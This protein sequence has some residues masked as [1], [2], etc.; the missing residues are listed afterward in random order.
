[1]TIIAHN[2]GGLCNR[3]KNIISCF[4]LTDDVLV[5]WKQIDKYDSKNYHLFICDYY[6]LFS[7]PFLIQ[8][9]DKEYDCYK[10][11][12]LIIQKS[13]KLPVNFSQFNSKCS[14]KYKL[15]D[16]YKRNIDFEYERIP[17]NVK[18]TYIYLFKNKLILNPY[19]KNKIEIFFDK[20][21]KNKKL[22]GVHIRSWKR[23]NEEYRQHLH[24]LDEFEKEI[25]TKLKSYSVFVSCDNEEILQY[26]KKKYTII[27]YNRDTDLSSS[28]L[29]SEGIQE[30]LIELYLLSKCQTLIGSHFS[31]FS[32]VA[33]YLS[34]CVSI[35]II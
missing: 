14:K 26:L 22:C 11:S 13:D 17:D 31:S 12:K 27:V 6:K 23:D 19:I 7:Y 21:M 10:D 16:K 15:T 30:D 24:K 33:W 29:N 4:R 34:G 20:Y 32:E 25:Q 28:R 3:I 1:M 35:K 5:Y 2:T 9:L 18:E 8:N